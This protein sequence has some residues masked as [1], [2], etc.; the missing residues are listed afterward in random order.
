MTRPWL[1]LAMREDY[2]QI[3]KQQ[4][5]KEAREKAFKQKAQQA[6]QQAQ[7]GQPQQNGEGS[8][9]RPGSTVN[10]GQGQANGQ[11]GAK[12]EG[13]GT[14]SGEQSTVPKKPWDYVEEVMAALKTAFPHFGFWLFTLSAMFLSCPPIRGR[15]SYPHWRP[16]TCHLPRRMWVA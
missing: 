5:A 8:Q 11:N 3:R 14:P 4:E 1:F 2:H 13:Q 7:G 6:A 9:E 16:F 10:G 12:P 15:F